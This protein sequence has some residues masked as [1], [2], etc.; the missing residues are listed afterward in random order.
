MRNTQFQEAKLK[1]LI[2]LQGEDFTILRDT[3][4]ELGEPDGGESEVVSFRG[5]WHE[6]NSYVTTTKGDAA[7]VRSK[8]SPQILAMFDSVK[9]AKQGDFLRVGD[10]RYNVTG[11]D[12]LTQLGVAAD[13]SLEEVL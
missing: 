10:K 9:D 13:M 4:N 2:A 11:M 8:S 12:N 3:L 6:A 5:I 7:T 1:R